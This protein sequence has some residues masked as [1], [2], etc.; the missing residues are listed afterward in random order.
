MA[1]GLIDKFLDDVARLSRA[2]QDGVVYHANLLKESGV[3]SQ[4]ATKWLV[5]RGWQPLHKGSAK[6]VVIEKWTPP[7]PMNGNIEQ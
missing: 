5:N 3:S 7:P 4:N 1:S 6:K 2:N